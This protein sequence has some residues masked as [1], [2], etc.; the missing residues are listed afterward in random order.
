MSNALIIFIYSIAAYG[1]CNM[2]AFGSGPFKIFEKIREWSYDISEH[3]SS[4]F[5]CM[6]CLPANI[7]WITSLINWF[8]IPVKITPF[9][10]LL[11]GT[12]L[13]WIALIC[14][15]CFTSGIVW[16]IHNIESFFENIMNNGSDIQDENNEVLNLHD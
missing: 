14:D 6:M 3:F 9:N 2:I 16:I 8:F 11:A 1:I 15:C 7:G 4:L 13:W 12:N 10:L 5:S